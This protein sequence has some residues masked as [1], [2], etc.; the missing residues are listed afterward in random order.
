MRTD[1]AR[2]PASAA[3]G[4]TLLEHLEALRGTLLRMLVATALLYPVGYAL[5]PMAT[6]MLVCLC[7]PPETGPLHFFAPMEVFWTRLRLALVIA[8]AIAHPWNVWQLWGF[9]VPALH[10]GERVALRRWVVASTVLFAVG[11]AFCVGLILPLVM[12]FSASF[13]TP[14]LRPVLGLAQFLGLS[15]W[16]VLAF[17]TMFQAP[18]VAL[19][20]VRLGL[21]A[22]DTLARA[23]PYVVVGIL[24]LAAILTPPDVVSQLLLAVPSW[25]LFELG[26]VIARR[27][28]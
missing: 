20:A 7:L 4:E 8:I 13:A 28:R 12:R 1:D 19:G 25:L 9:V 23:R 21:V 6:R 16:L 17:G 5:A 26:L 11:A 22:P 15:G 10:P 18:L 27:R 14:D 3:E 2:P 24:L